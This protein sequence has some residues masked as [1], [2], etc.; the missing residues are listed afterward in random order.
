MASHLENVTFDSLIHY[1]EPTA[2]AAW[3]AGRAEVSVGNFVANS[4][5]AFFLFSCLFFWLSSLS[6]SL[7]FF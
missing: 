3:F 5:F 7:M 2:T 6:S 1:A 4:F